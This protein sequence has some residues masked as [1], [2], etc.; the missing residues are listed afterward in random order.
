MSDQYSFPDSFLWGT[1]IAAHQVEGNNKNNDWWRW[2]QS[3]TPDR[4]YP[5]EPSNEACDFYNRY[6]EDFDICQEFN[7]NAIRLS[8]EWA[9]I[10][11]KIDVYDQTAIDHYKK[12]FMAARE[13]G[14]QI[15]L[16]LHHF[17]SPVWFADRGGW[18]ARDAVAIFRQ[19]AQVCAEEF[20]DYVDAFITINEPQVYALKSYTDGTWPPN[21]RN[22]WLS[23]YV[24]IN[25]M[26][27]HRSAYD[28][29]KTICDTPVG[30]AKNIVWYDTNPFASNLIDRAAARFLNYLNDDFFLL[31]LMGKIDFL[32]LNYY[33]TQRLHYL[34]IDNPN[35][36]VSDMG[37][38][39]NP[40]GLGEILQKLKKYKVPIY[41]T[42]N[43]L[44]DATD[45]YREHFLRDMLIAC[46]QAILSGV[47][48]RGYF[49]WSLMD[50]YEWHEGFWPRFG[51]VEIDRE[52]NLAR[53]PR[54]SFYYYAKVCQNNTVEVN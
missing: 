44:A 19:Y 38:W 41:I 7:T 21:L 43:G 31:P 13:R 20:S 27:A 36:Y 29:I 51:L 14:L 39:I 52:H 17:T 23:Y 4:K 18:H 35:D 3:K 22:P 12:M 47:D 34:R 45:R 42:E 24:Q 15:F 25:L 46:G 2:E 30:L 50:N 9:R 53:K 16:T 8:V 32:G 6:E 26:R 28:A 11:P 10:Q 37:W 1:A 48:L 33:F 5:L 40:G 54:Q 49:H